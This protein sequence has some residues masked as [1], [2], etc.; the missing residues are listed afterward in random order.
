MG[1]ARFWSNAAITRDDTRP[2]PWAIML[3]AAILGICSAHVPIAGVF[4]AP[5]IGALLALN[6]RRQSRILLAILMLGLLLDIKTETASA[7]W[8]VIALA[9]LTAFAP[10]GWVMRLMFLPRSTWQILAVL[11]SASIC[12]ML[13]GYGIVPTLLALSMTFCLGA[14]VTRQM[15]N[16]DA[17]L[18]NWGDD[19]LFAVTRDLLLGRVTR[20]MLHDLAQPLNVISMA[21]GNMGYIA[22][23][24][25]IGEDER[26]QLLD[27]V[28]RISQHTSNA[29]SILSLFR[30]FGR[31]GSDEAAQLSVRS[32]LERAVGATRS[33][34]RHHDVAVDVQG[35]ALDY[36]LT[37]RHGSLEIIA[38][39]A[40]LCAFASFIG[41]DGSK[42][43]GRVLLHATLSPAY[44]IV[45]VRC[46]DEAGQPVPGK[47][48][49]HATMWLVE[50]VA[51]EASGDFR[52]LRQSVGPERFVIR[53]GRDDT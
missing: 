11:S 25:A 18:L 50:Q 43:R 7:Y 6:A 29:A 38:V 44:V 36:I 51:H 4:T 8:T 1:L 9:G 5:A 41:P 26:Q 2:H 34:V 27:R 23:H 22:E 47:T 10:R 20:G 48:M 24:L 32:A 16:I 17:R 45:S 39:A 28:E 15:S 52:C 33:N 30:W 12:A 42:R 14:Q 35:N 53:L 37:A 13:L 46:T 19:G 21:N 40:L 3:S 49:D 31:D